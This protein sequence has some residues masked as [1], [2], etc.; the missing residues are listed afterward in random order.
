MILYPIYIYTYEHCS[1]TTVGVVTGATTNMYLCS[2][3]SFAF[4]LA[5]DKN[6]HF[7]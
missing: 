1:L 2:L 5:E 7:V 3:F 4:V 6:I